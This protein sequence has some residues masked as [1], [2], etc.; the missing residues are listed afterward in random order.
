MS[1]SHS[2]P[3]LIE[4]ARLREGRL[5]D[6]VLKDGV[7]AE[8]G[9]AASRSSAADLLPESTQRI[10]AQGGLLLPGL[11]DHHIHLFATARAL[12]SV[13]LD[14]S[15]RWSEDD[16]I[17]ALTTALQQGQPLR[18][19][20]LSAER[21]PQIDASWLDQLSNKVAIRLQ[22]RTGQLWIYNSTALAEIKALDQEWPV[23]TEMDQQ[24]RPNGRFWHLGGWLSE[25]RQNTF[26][27][28]SVLSNL[29]ASW[30]ITAVTDAGVHNDQT[31]WWALRQA[32]RLGQLKQRLRVMGC[33]QLH[34]VAV[35]EPEWCALGPV[36][37]YLRESALPD[38]NTL[39][40]QIADAHATGRAVAFHCVT[41][42]ELWV[43]IDALRQVGVID[44]DRIEHASL[45]DDDALS[46]LTTLGIRVVTQPQFLWQRGD[47]YCEQLQVE[48]LDILYRGQSWLKRGIPVSWG[49]DA[50]YGDSNPWLA[51]QA[52]LD[53]T[54]STG[55]I[56]TTS[57]RLRGEQLWQLLG[58]DTA[59][60]GAPMQSLAVGCA[61]DLCLLKQ[62]I[63]QIQERPMTA[64]V[65]AT[66]VAGTQIYAG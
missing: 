48:D 52:A 8:I 42:V 32:Q 57:E 51:M 53:R 19:V 47:R 59:A 27:D 54:T 24:G 18:G 62:S 49:S 31:V 21:F 12:Q 16:L 14:D 35:D 66:F 10:D 39:V 58:S 41:R 61:A 4:R 3:V 43:A 30:G 26:P 50:P 60:P 46:E 64:E 44:G 2:S 11:V 9:Q 36:K 40:G 25:Q 6:V 15:S 28:L 7:I 17:A 38:G 5:V 33:H 55:A 1:A 34:R 56:I 13:A 22:D 23:G 20:N 65:L 29:L 37:I 63:D 45:V